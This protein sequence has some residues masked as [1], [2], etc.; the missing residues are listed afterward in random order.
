[1]DF[2]KLTHL[3]NWHLDQETK[4]WQP[5]RSLLLSSSFTTSSNDKSSTDFQEHRLV[6]PQFD[7]LYKWNHAEC[8]LLCLPSFAHF[9]KIDL[10]GSSCSE[11]ILFAVWYF[12]GYL[13]QFIYPFC[14]WLAYEWF[15]F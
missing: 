13:P 7:L 4:H 3:H 11:V 15:L 8:T 10:D 14:C 1:M 9:C 2:H 6:L 12:R 5:C